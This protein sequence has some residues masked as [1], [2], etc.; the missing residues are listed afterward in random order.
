M[1]A[2][3]VIVH[4]EEIEAWFQPIVGAAPFKVEGYEIQSHFRGEPLKPFFQEDDVP[5]E[6]QLEVM[7]RK[8]M[9]Q[10]SISSK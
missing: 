6:Y 2:L 3:D 1:D 4:P 9:F 8:M 7:V 5:I 10:S